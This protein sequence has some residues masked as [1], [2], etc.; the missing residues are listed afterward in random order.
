MKGARS[1]KT[2]CLI[3]ADIESVHRE[4]T[5]I[6]GEMV[7]EVARSQSNLHEVHPSYEASA[8]N[9]LH[10]LALRR[11][12]L[13]SLQRRL[14]A[15]GLSSLGR[16]E[17]HVLATVDTVLEVLGRLT[18]DS[19]RPPSE[20]ATV[21]DIAHGE[22]LL[23]EHADGLLGATGSGRGVRIMVTMPS[24]AADDYTLVHTLLQ[25]GMDCMRINCAHD[26][27]T[28]WLRMI[29]HLKRAEQ[30]VG[31]SCR[32]V[33]D[34]GGPKLRLVH[35]SRVSPSSGFGPTVM[36]MDG[37][38]RQGGFGSRRS[39]LLTNLP[40]AGGCVPPS[41]AEMVGPPAPW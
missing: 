34:L 25:Q 15:L 17:S 19:G 11:R 35:C 20:E 40:R 33:M 22:Q 23:A 10:Y 24:E 5:L 3:E 28:A 2:S 8:R 29:Q 32:I 31:R 16:A 21:V 9:L 38:S 41:A 36:R 18:G 37:S 7:A 30:A 12:D 13:R 1:N 27:A 26:G 4:L 6:R 14:A 39:R